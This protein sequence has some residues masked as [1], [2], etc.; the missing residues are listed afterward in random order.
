VLL[1]LGYLTV[2]NIFAMLRLPPMGERDK[3]VEILALRHQIAVLERQRGKQRVR[4]TPGIVPSSRHFCTG[5]QRT[6]YDGCDSLWLR[7]KMSPPPRKCY[8]S[9]RWTPDRIELWDRDSVHV[10]AVVDVRGRRL[11][12]SLRTSDQTPLTPHADFPLTDR[13]RF[14]VG[15][16][17]IF[18]EFGIYPMGRDGAVDSGV[19]HGLD[20][21]LAVDVPPVQAVAF[22]LDRIA[23]AAQD[24]Q[25]FILP[26]DQS[27]AGGV[28][29]EVAVQVLMVDAVA[30]GAAQQPDRRS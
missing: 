8:E 26:A 2:S 10:C 4:F 5:C 25:G 15:P 14:S 16:V 23:A 19:E 6:C 7:Y 21:V 17:G 24:K 29:G 18:E 28:F 1:R 27:A 3:E 20:A 12:G 11:L 9:G 22:E 13:C 30:V